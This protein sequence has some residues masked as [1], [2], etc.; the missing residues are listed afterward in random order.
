[1]TKSIHPIK[2][3]DKVTSLEV[4]F[5]TPDAPPP[6]S[7]GYRLTANIKEDGIDIDFVLSYTDR[8]EV[9]EEEILAEGFTL[10]DDFSFKGVLPASWKASLLS[11]LE[12]ASW[13]TGSQ[14]N[15]F[16]FFRIV[17]QE[18][19][20]PLE[21]YPSDFETWEYFLQ[22][23][24]QAIFEAGKKERPLEVVYK[25]ITKDRGT[26]TIFLSGSFLQRE[27]KLTVAA[28]N[29]QESRTVE[30]PWK[31]LRKMLKAIYLPDYDPDLAQA[32]EPKKA[33]RY[34]NPG[35]GLWYELGKA[36]TNPNK[37]I[38]SLGILESEFSRWVSNI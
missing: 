35:D 10:N 23:M 5:I 18:T 24:V 31:N 37:E 34:L 32:Q 19:K 26:Q 30:L 27:A 6:Y 25:D 22:E 9:D 33:G 1:M 2:T 7:Y 16:L 36:I 15:S 8:D 11:R 12:H 13:I 21:G 38:D 4:N 28:E 3:P 29:G 17:S 20:K 14:E